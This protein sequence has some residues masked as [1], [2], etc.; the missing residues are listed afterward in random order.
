MTHSSTAAQPYSARR[1][2]RLTATKARLC[3]PHGKPVQRALPSAVTGQAESPCLR[4]LVLQVAELEAELFTGAPPP[5]SQAADTAPAKKHKKHKYSQAHADAPPQPR[6]TEEEAGPSQQHSE[7]EP[8]S[9][10][11]LGHTE[12]HHRHSQPDRRPDHH[13]RDRHASNL[14]T[15]HKRTH[16][17]A[18]AHQGQHE[19]EP[20]PP[21]PDGKPRGKRPL[22]RVQRLIEEKKQAQADEA[23]RKKEVRALVCVCV[24]ACVCVCVCVFV[25]A[26]CVCMCLGAPNIGV[27]DAYSEA[28]F[29][30][31]YCVYKAVCAFVCVCVCVCVL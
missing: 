15:G 7:P 8:A 29:D 5:Q 18:D 25:C 6:H 19:G 20:G 17:E 28:R 1:L 27:C 2:H 16:S 4:L 3:G 30:P 21:A 24:R 31:C 26:L 13:S 23:A 10:K 11:G 12:Q 22:S 9:R 14:H